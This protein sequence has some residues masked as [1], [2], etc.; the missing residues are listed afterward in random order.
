MKNIIEIN[1]EGTEEN[2]KIWFENMINEEIEDTEDMI[3]NEELWVLGAADEEE[4]EMHLDNI[5]Q[6]KEYIKFLKYVAKKFE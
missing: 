5:R 2:I 6:G 3:E 1:F 4:A